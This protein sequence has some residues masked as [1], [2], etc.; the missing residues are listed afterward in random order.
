MSILNETLAT[1]VKEH[2]VLCT[3]VLL[4]TCN[5]QSLGHSPF[6]IDENLDLSHPVS[7][8]CKF[9]LGAGFAI[10]ININAYHDAS[11]QCLCCQLYVGMYR[12]STNV[13]IQHT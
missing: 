11:S 6:S 7:D 9:C 8:A 13:F 10:R 12:F 4:S 3:Q 2:A 5:L 1:F